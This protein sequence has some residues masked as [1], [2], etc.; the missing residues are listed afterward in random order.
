MD[1]SDITIGKLR[2]RYVLDGSTTDSLGIFEM[3]VPAG[4]NVPPPHSHSN[5]EEGVYVLEG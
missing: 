1:T 2:I 3:T 4:S 5:N